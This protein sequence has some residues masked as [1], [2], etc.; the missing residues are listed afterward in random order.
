VGKISNF[1]GYDL[2]ESKRTTAEYPNNVVGEEE[3]N[4]DN[5]FRKLV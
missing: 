1:I 3:E 4:V 5:P 2:L